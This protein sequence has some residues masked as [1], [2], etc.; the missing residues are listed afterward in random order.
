MSSDLW[1]ETP[2]LSNLHTQGKYKAL[3]DIPETKG[4]SPTAI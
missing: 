3:N 4:F 1:A 2:I